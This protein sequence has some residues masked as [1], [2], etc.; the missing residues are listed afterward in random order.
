MRDEECVFCKI[1]AG[2]I[3]ADVVYDAEEVLAFR[4]LN[5]RA[6]VHVLVVPKRH[7]GSLAGLDG[8]PDAAVRQV[9]GAPQAVAEETGVAEGGYAV[10]INT[11]P[12]AGQEVQHLH[13]HVLGG[14]RIMMPEVEG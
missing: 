8:L 2:E 13:L 9:F 5:A 4:D 3:E 14:A 7:V 12:D 11:G 1:V 10:R 6:P